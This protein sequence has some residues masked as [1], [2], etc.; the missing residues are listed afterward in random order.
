MEWTSITTAISLGVIAICVLAL[1]ICTLWQKKFIV[2]MQNAP[3]S[4]LI[5]VIGGVEVALIFAVCYIYT[6]K[7][8]FDSEGSAGILV[9]A[10]S[11]LVTL[12][13]AWQIYNTIEVDK[14][15][16]FI[17]GDLLHNRYYADARIHFTQAQSL[18]NNTL[19]EIETIK[20]NNKKGKQSDENYKEQPINPEFVGNLCVAYRNFLEA[21][22]YYLKST[23]D[24]TAINSCIN[25]MNSCLLHLS[26]EKVPFRESISK[27]CDKL[28]EELL[29]A[30]LI[31]SPRLAENLERLNKTRT[32]K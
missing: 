8:T 3:Y 26:A 2:T 6:N 4:T 24:A 25:N 12:L 15:I 22:M 10:L 20:T 16:S 7:L 27:K 11:V 14:K 31:L 1:T 30:Q 5:F 19:S 13:V 9:A 18:M 29:F 23:K 21:I 28:Y 32:G 17:K